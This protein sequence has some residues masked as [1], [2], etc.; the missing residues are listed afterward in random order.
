MNIIT[1]ILGPHKLTYQLY[2]SSLAASWVNHWYRVNPRDNLHT[3][4]GPQVRKTA[5]QYLSITTWIDQPEGY[6]QTPVHSYQWRWFREQSNSGDLVMGWHSA[7]PELRH[8]Y[9]LRDVDSVRRGGLR[10]VDSITPEIQ[11]H[12][13]EIPGQPKSYNLDRE[14]LWWLYENDLVDCLPRQGFEILCHANPIIAKLID[15]T[16]DYLLKNIS[17]DD[18]ITSIQVYPPACF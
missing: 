4:F 12:F 6:Q 8:L 18:R 11:L 3:G 15:P 5:E 9:R 1:V 16:V 7:D 2:D 13:G 17:T 10:V 14:I